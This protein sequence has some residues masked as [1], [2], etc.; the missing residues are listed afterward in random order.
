[1]KRF[2][3]LAAATAALSL[4]FS[5]TGEEEQT[6]PPS[7][8]PPYCENNPEFDQFDFWVGT[9]DVYVN[10]EERPYAGRNVITK[11]ASECLVMEHWTN[12]RGSSGYSMNYYDPVDKQWRQVWV[13]NNLS[14]DYAGGLNEDGQMV[15]EGEAHYYNRGASFPFRGVWTPN[16]DGTVRQ[17]FEQY[18][19]ETDAWE[20]WFDG[21]YV[22]ADDEA[23][24]EDETH[25]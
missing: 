6:A 19:P 1:M 10:S 25:R 7:P 23:G 18:N 4:A 20:P 21:L 22:R 14:I 9:W 16:E 5:A 13:S 12:R 24:G 8:P 3:T 15:L 2:A 11:V 17:Y